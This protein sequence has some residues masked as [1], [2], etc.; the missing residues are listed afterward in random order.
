MSPKSFT[1]SSKPKEESTPTFDVVEITEF[2]EVKND[3]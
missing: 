3:E 2:E 1:V